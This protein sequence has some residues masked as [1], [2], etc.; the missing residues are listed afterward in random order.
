M[1]FRPLYFS[2]PARHRGRQSGFTAIELLVT[3]SVLGILL[4][5]AIPSFADFTRA[6]RG[7]SL[8]SNFVAGMTRAR[9]EAI[10]QN[11]CV[12]ICQ[13]A[14]A[15]N[16]A[17][18]TCDDSVDDWQRGWIVFRIPDCDTTLD[19]PVD[20]DVLAV[21]VSEYADFELAASTGAVRS[22]MF[23][24]RGVLR[25]GGNANLT[26][27]YVPDGISSKHT[28]SVCV[29]IAGRVTVRRYGGTTGCTG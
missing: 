21:R 15:A 7:S 27:K 25:S 26:L 19:N 4:A 20:T 1:F 14:N 18:A 10:S 9:T 12:K 6:S 8:S 16:G 22:F 11:V 13:S 29:S 28:R 24:P 3:I 17:S 23:D 2:F 5:L